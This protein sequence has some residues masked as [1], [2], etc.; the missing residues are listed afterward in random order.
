MLDSV[1][2]ANGRLADT[3]ADKLR[4]NHD[5]DR[6]LVSFQANR[7]ETAIGGVNTRKDFLLP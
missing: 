3:Y 7:R 1:Y 5:L 2:E 6:T 4:V